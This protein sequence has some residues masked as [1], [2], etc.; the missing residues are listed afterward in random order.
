[1]PNPR[2]IRQIPLPKVTHVIII[3][4]VGLDTAELHQ[5]L[6]EIFPVFLCD[7]ILFRDAINFFLSNSDDV[8]VRYFGCVRPGQIDR[9]AG[10]YDCYEV[11]AVEGDVRD[12]VERDGVPYG[13]YAGGCPFCSAFSL[14]ERARC[15]YC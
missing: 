6:H 9:G 5:L 14:E 7:G 11:V 8:P 2:I 13:L 1:M 15:Y 10:G 4:S 12:A 3:R